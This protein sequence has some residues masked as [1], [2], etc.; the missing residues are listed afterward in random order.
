MEANSEKSRSTVFDYLTL[1]LLV[2]IIAVL[3]PI[4]VSIVAA[5]HLTSISASYHTYA[6]DIFVGMLFIVGVFLFAYNGHSAS[7]KWASRL[8]AVAAITAAIFPT[9]CE[10]DNCLPYFAF[11]DVYT[12]SEI[13][14][15]AAIVLFIVLAY[16][17]LGPFRQKAREKGEKGKRRSII[18][19]FCGSIM[20]G[21]IVSA[22]L[23][24]YTLQSD[25]VENLRILYW[26][27]FV[28]LLVFGIAWFVAGRWYRL[29][30]LVDENEDGYRPFDYNAEKADKTSGSSGPTSK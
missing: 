13:H 17:C 7:Q 3:M 10:N 21:C 19:I 30:L 18:Y 14:N 6:R 1:R 15:Y 9:S 23:A 8:A 26:A 22:V 27:E 20:I 24:I 28:G 2:G 11:I 29:T 25:I 16:F 4:I 5:E 12:A